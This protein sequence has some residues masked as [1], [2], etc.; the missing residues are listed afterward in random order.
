MIV[1]ASDQLAAASLMQVVS[2]RHP[3][4]HHGSKHA[5]TDKL[6]QTHHGSAGR[7]RQ[8]LYVMCKRSCTEILYLTL[9]ILVL[10]AGLSSK[11]SS[12]QAWR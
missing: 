11:Q 12:L 9:L 4:Q 7:H 2:D 1:S 6:L 10:A 8:H 5:P 3:R